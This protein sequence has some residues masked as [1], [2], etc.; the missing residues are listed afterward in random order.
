MSVPFGSPSEIVAKPFYS[1]DDHFHLRF[2]QIGVF[3]TSIE[4]SRQGGDGVQIM[5]IPGK[6]ESPQRVTQRAREWMCP[7]S[8]FGNAG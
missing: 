6:C 3:W 4:N 5:R 1:N 7:T 8:N 2:A